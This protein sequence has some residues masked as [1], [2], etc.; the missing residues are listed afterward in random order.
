[1][2]KNQITLV[3]LCLV[4]LFPIAFN[5]AVAAPDALMFV[6]PANI[7][8]TDLEPCSDITI[9]IN[10]STVPNLFTWQ[11]KLWFDPSIINCT[12]AYY[13]P[14]HVFDGMGFIP[15][16][17]VID[18][19]NGYVTFGASLIASPT[20]VDEGV[21]CAI[22]FHVV[23]IG[24]CELTLDP[25]E[26]FFL[27]FD[28]VDIPT[29]IQNGFFSNVPTPFHDVAVI[30]LSLSNNRPK[31]NDTVSIDV[32]VLNNGSLAE[33]FDVNVYYDDNLID[34][35]NVASLAPDDSA[36]LSFDWNTTGV[37]LGSHIIKAEAE[38]VPG[39]TVTANNV[40]TTTAIV[41]SGLAPVTD[42]NGDGVVDMRDIAEAARAYGS[43]P[44][45]DRYEEALD[46]NGDGEI[47]ILDIALIAQDF[48][49]GIM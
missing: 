11:I 23:G 19:V 21:L 13:P 1:M 9:T 40:R 38:V 35:E 22:D 31:Q 37:E 34:T 45:H 24:S 28:L 16:D 15:V 8:D 36:M 18:N 43:Y 48:G 47:N 33:T 42:T 4:I 39:E 49:Y 12:D 26:S 25:G 5:K 32:E 29:T 20:D 46:V 10:A 3:F 2:K 7:I 17:P 44:G 27:D 41:L 6:D 30:D 14:G